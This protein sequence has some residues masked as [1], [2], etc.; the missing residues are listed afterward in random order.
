MT[1]T[2]SSA[3][4]LP[5]CPYTA[6][7][8]AEPCT[9][10]GNVT[11]VGATWHT[12]HLEARAPHV[13]VGHDEVPVAGEEGVPAHRPLAAHGLGAGAAVAEQGGIV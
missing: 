4:R 5:S 7:L 2:V 10:P 9:P 11:R 8:K 12:A 13:D 3:S 1:A 6:W